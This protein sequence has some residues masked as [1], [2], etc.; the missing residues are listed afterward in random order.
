MAEWNQS[1]NAPKGKY[2]VI[3]TDS[4]P[5]PHEDYWI[6]DSAGFPQAKKLA[7]SHVKEMNSVAIYDEIGKLV[8]SL[9]TDDPKV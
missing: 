2:R 4:F 6:G 7:S 9:S 5:W 3:G 8:F 1:K